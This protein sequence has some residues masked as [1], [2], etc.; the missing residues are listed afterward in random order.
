MKIFTKELR[1]NEVKNKVEKNKNWKEK[2][3]NKKFKTWNKKIHVWFSTIWNNKIF[4]WRY[5]Y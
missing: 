1:T 5:F 3:K 2:N 4:K